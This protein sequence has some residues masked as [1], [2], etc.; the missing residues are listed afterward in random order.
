MLKNPKLNTR[1]EYSIDSMLRGGGRPYILWFRGHPLAQRDKKKDLEAM[2]EEHFRLRKLYDFKQW[3]LER[4][5][6]TIS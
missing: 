6:L 4:G 1:A 5:C 2:K 3:D